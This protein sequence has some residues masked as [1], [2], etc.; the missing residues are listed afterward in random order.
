[1]FLN[2]SKNYWK[3][4]KMTSSLHQIDKNYNFVYIEAI[5]LVE[6]VYSQYQ[7]NTNDNTKK[8]FL[9]M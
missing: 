1:M 2:Y 6:I 3:I 7:Q 4:E 9:K 5:F 8:G